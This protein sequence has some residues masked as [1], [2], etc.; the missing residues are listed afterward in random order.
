M[1]VDYVPLRPR[2]P[3]ACDE[4]EAAGHLCRPC[5]KALYQRC[6]DRRP[7]RWTLALFLL[8]GVV[9]GIAW[10]SLSWG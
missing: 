7:P 2:R 8:A 3:F 1:T 4:C 5:R 10:G 6:H 9:L